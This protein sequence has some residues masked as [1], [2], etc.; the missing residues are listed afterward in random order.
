MADHL[1]HKPKT[2]D[3]M[4]ADAAEAL[5]EAAKARVALA[6]AED[7]VSWTRKAVESYA[8]LSKPNESPV[9]PRC[10]DQRLEKHL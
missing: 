7:R 6:A 10:A 8:R 9:S 2:F 1:D 5:A 3:D 4:I